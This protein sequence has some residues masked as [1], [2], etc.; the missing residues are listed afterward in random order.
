MPKIKKNTDEDDFKIIEEFAEL[1]RKEALLINQQTPLCK[2]LD[3]LKKKTLKN[4]VRN[5]I[6]KKNLER[7]PPSKK[8]I[9]EQEQEIRNMLNHPKMTQE[10]LELYI[11]AIGYSQKQTIAKPTE[12]F[13][14]TDYYKKEYYQYIINILN[15]IKENDL[16]IKSLNRML[17]NP[18]GNYMSKCLNC[19]LNP[20]NKN[21]ENIK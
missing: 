5:A 21:I 11:S 2:Q 8:E 19:P 18:Y 7:N 9:Q 1:N 13:D 3:Q 16:N 15:T 10:I 12:I 6:N 17:D 14:N 4:K 20:F